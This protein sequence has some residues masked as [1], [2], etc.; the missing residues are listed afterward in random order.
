MRKMR[1]W[2]RDVRCLE[3]PI[4]ASMLNRSSDETQP[5]DVDSSKAMRVDAPSSVSITKSRTI[6]LS[7]V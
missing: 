4:P 6:L 1:L 3:Y 2:I 5:K 7:V